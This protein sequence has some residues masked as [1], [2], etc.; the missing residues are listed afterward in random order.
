[1]NLNFLQFLQDG[2]GDFSSM[3]GIMIA[4]AIGVLLTWMYASVVSSALLPIPESVIALIGILVTGK[5]VQ[6]KI[7][8]KEGCNEPK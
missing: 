2:N 7:E 8:K 3:R 6:K 4:W 5:A 1:M